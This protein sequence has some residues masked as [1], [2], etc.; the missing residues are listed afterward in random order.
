[1]VPVP[2]LRNAMKLAEDHGQTLDAFITDALNAKV[3][4][5]NSADSEAF[6]GTE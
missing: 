6:V 5:L 1:M 4:E 2:L 3:A